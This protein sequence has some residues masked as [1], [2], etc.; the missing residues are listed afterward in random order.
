MEAHAPLEPFL[1]YDV[2]EAVHGYLDAS[3]S[4]EEQSGD[5][6][7]EAVDCGLG[8]RSADEVRTAG[9]WRVK[10]YRGEGKCSSC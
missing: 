1:R 5:Y 8:D 2:C 6:E 7:G 4:K 10:W 9:L 3:E